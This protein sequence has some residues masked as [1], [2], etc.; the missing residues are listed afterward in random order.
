M[1]KM[2][3]DLNKPVKGLDGADLKDSNLS[4]ILANALCGKTEGIEPVKAIDWAL[5]LYNEGFIEIDDSD[6]EKLKN[7]IEKEE[8]FTNLLKAS[9]LKEL[10]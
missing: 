9:L 10:K 2:K 5:K 4:K 8:N 7:F 3:L 6:T 1:S